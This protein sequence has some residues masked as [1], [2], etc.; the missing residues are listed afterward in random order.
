VTSQILTDVSEVLTVII[1]IRAMMI[2]AISASEMSVSFYEITRRNI[3]DACH[4]S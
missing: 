3:P 2:E 1:I 4:L